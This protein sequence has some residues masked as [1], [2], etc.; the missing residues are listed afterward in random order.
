MCKNDVSSE[1][2]QL[3]TKEIEGQDYLK[4]FKS[5]KHRSIPSVYLLD[6]PQMVSFWG[7]SCGVDRVG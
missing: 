1:L 2:L 5:L 3:K 4:L 6:F 7:V